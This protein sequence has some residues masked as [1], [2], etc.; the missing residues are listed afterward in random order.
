MILGEKSVIPENLLSLLF[1]NEKALAVLQLDT[2]AAV[3]IAGDVEVTLHYS[4]EPVIRPDIDKTLGVSLKLKD[5]E[6][7]ADVALEVP[8]DW[9]I[10]T[11]KEAMGQKRFV[12]RTAKVQN[13]NTIGV[14]VTLPDGQRRTKFLILGPEE[15]R[16]YP[17]GT[18]V[19]TCPNCHAWQ[20]ACICGIEQSSELAT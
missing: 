5:T 12:V 13:Y 2:Q 20:D 16:G 17:S 6:I 3:A 15:A 7:Q 10:K 18:R 9:E 11:A 14:L 1:R 4:G 8:G 19:P